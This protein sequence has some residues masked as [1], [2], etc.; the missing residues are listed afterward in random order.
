MATGLDKTNRFLKEYLRIMQEGGH[1]FCCIDGVRYHY[2]DGVWRIMDDASMAYYNSYAYR[3]ADIYEYDFVAKKAQTWDAIWMR[4]YVEDAKMDQD[5]LTVC[6]N[7]TFNLRTGDKFENKPTNYTTRRIVTTY[8]PTKGCPQWEAMLGRIFSDLPEAEAKEHIDFLQEFFGMAVVGFDATTPV[9]RGLRKGLILHGPAA[10]GKTTIANV[11]RTLIGND[12]VV[13]PTLKQLGT[14]FGK[15]SLL[16]AR[17][18]IADDAITK[19]MS[20]DP[21]TLKHIVTGETMQVEQK[22]EKEISFQFHGAVV[23]TANELPKISDETDSVY[24][25]YVIMTTTKTFDPAQARKDFPPHGDPVKY[26]L[27]CGE[28]SGILNWAIEGYKRAIERGALVVPA[29]CLD[30]AEAARRENDGVY[31]FLK[32]C[33][34]YDPSVATSLKVARAAAAQ[35][36]TVVHSGARSDKMSLSETGARLKRAAPQVLPGV[37]V[38]RPIAYKGDTYRCLTGLRLSGD[39]ADYARQAVEGGLLKADDLRVL[40]VPSG[41]STSAP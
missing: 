38:D 14:Q 34:E 22:F 20:P 23:F 2:Q 39:G 3:S 19:K 17:A 4:T 31:A 32:E 35:Y 33:A 41:A 27:D 26:L 9:P 16:N 8:D 40:N 12:H 30:A 1:Y 37:K 7:G 10:T 24:Q 25:R 15:A 11:L 18:I 36:V 28:M 13:S 6:P 29:R 5:L 21:L